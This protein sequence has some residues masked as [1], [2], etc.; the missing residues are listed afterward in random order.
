MVN[1]VNDNKNNNYKYINNKS[2][3]IKYII[4]LK[5]NKKGHYVNKYLILKIKSDSY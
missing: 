4:Y 1:H 5:Y 3:Y 2:K